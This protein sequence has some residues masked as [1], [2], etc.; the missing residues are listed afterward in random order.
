MPLRACISSEA[1]LRLP[2]PQPAL[3]YQPQML[4]A[5]SGSSR[6]LEAPT[7]PQLPPDAHM[8]PTPALDLEDRCVQDARC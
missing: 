4:R 1:T 6:V 2:Q 7:A 3:R 8:T 5:Y